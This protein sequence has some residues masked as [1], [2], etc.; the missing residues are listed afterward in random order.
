MKRIPLCKNAQGFFVDTGI[1]SA[2]SAIFGSLACR[3][4]RRASDARRFEQRLSRLASL[5]SAASDCSPDIAEMPESEYVKENTSVQRGDE[6]FY[7]FSYSCLD[8]EKAHFSCYYILG[9]NDRLYLVYDIHL[10]GE[11]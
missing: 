11:T 2:I 8:S 9:F 5:T 10:V 6:E 3:A 7:C 4:L 1:D